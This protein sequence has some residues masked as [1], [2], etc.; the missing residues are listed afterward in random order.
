M[1]IPGL[2]NV[3]LGSTASDIGSGVNTFVQGMIGQRMRESQLALQKAMAESRQNLEA[4]QTQDIQQQEIE[5]QHE[6]EPAG[7]AEHLMLQQ[8]FPHVPVNMWAT[9]GI[10]RRDAHDLAKTGMLMQR[11]GMTMTRFDEN[12][13]A[14]QIKQF[15]DDPE[16]K[17]AKGV[18]QGYRNLRAMLANPTP[19]AQA[20]FFLDFAQTL[21]IPGMNNA[22]AIGTELNALL[23]GGSLTYTQE[24]QRFLNKLGTEG[25]Q[26]TFDPQTLASMPKIMHDVL[27]ARINRYDDLRMDVKNRTRIIYG[28]EAP[29]AAIGLDPF[30]DI[31]GDIM[32]VSKPGIQGPHAPGGTGGSG[33]KL[34][35]I[36]Q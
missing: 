24:I 20:S 15:N 5:R 16:V 6:N 9:S 19:A 26:F 12:A 18:A 22:R 33:I 2:P 30:R 23:R 8:S 36:D 27:K 7:P 3:Q 25:D 29:D 28:T 21:G 14:Q 17:N 11:M 31:R 32:E 35:G 1:T 13:M 4:A 10:S 34:P